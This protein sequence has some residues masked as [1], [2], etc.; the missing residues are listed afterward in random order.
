MAVVAVEDLSFARV[1]LMHLSEVTTIAIE[2]I[3]I[4]RALEGSYSLIFDNRLI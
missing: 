2:A 3:V 1:K 4:R